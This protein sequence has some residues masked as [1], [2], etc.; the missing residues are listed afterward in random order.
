LRQCW[1]NG[2]F[3]ILSGVVVVIV[4]SGFDLLFYPF[5]A[6][7]FLDWSCK[8]TIVATL[9]FSWRNGCCY[10]LWSLQLEL[11]VCVLSHAQLR[12]LRIDANAEVLRAS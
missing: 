12:G 4:I 5:A 11:F 3:A 1:A 7:G 10:R 2:L 6:I 8:S 9:A